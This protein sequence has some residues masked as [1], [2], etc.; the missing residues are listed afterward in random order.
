MR[1]R[2]GWCH[3]ERLTIRPT[4]VLLGGAVL[5][6]V[7]G[8]ALVGG[9]RGGEHAAG[10]AGRGQGDVEVI[11]L[12]GRELR[13]MPAGDARAKLEID[14]AAARADRSRAPD[15]PEQIVWVARRL[16]YLWRMN[17][18]L[19]VLS[20]GI[21]R[22]PEYAPLYRH[23]G[24]RY[25]SVRRFDEAVDDLRRAAALIA[26]QPDEIEPD[27]MPNARN[28]PL[29]TTG[30]NVW[31]HLALAEYLRGDF[32][33]A[34]EG[35]RRTREYSRGLP[36]NLVAVTHWEYLTLRRLGRE[37]EAQRVLRT[38]D[39]GWEMIENEAYLRCVRLYMGELAA[40]E[41][42]AEESGRGAVAD[43]AECNGLATWYFVNGR[44]E[45]A[46]AVY[47]RIVA[48]EN[49]PAF[50]FIAAEAELARMRGVQG[51]SRSSVQAPAA[52]RR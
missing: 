30:F 7:A 42:C 50:G 51:A 13:A 27:G 29:T 1:S 34:L 17:E 41:L 14:L 47:E 37:E 24:H 39:P 9:N 12:L 6:V 18:A 15:D 38:V 52:V 36:D 28:I 20:E 25:I 45:Q 8:C 26:G 10:G 2:G 22:F 23:R 32:A 48:G 21:R 35:W 40:E 11:S 46:R 49:W 19:E 16:G 3:A 4:S 43:A 31:Y 33:A 5:S 44:E